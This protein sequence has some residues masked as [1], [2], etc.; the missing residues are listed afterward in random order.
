MNG[1]DNLIDAP[2]RGAPLPEVRNHTPYP[3]QYYQMMDVADRV[4][5]VIATRITYDL[6]RLDANGVPQLA[7][8][9]SPLVTADQ[10]YGEPNTS[11]TIQESDF[12]P[13]KPKCD[14]LFANATAYALEGKAISRW[15]VGVRVGQWEKRLTVTGPRFL[16]RGLGGMRLTEPEPATT[17][18]IR[19]EHAFG[20]TC[21][22]PITP[23]AEQA[24]ELLRRFDAN[25]IGCGWTD[26]DWLKKSRIADIDAPRIE[27]F[28]QPFK[29]KHADRL[30]YPV[31]G[32]GPIGRW[33]QPRLKLA[34][35][36]DDE[37]KQSRWPRLP[38]DFDFAYWNCAPEDQQIAYPQGGEH[39][40]LIGFT[41]KQPRF[42]F[43]LPRQAPHTLVRLKVGPRLPMLMK[44]DTLVFDMAAM[45]L[46]CVY[47]V[48]ITT[49]IETRAL[50]IRQKEV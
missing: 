42:E 19:Y 38:L 7:D 17:A 26:R 14:I 16:E 45:T 49:E 48:T 11:S 20:G 2:V 12:A 43:V 15:P 50:E 29:Q 39:V 9:Q 47:R 41:E 10:F 3:S 30:D 13:Y 22:W 32:L 34:G 6:T 25:P 24:P 33:W 36:Y 21:Q 37:W 31:V 18:Q 5:H 1:P 4:F 23:V 28:E 40:V 8:E 27:A 44:L 46:A 35:T